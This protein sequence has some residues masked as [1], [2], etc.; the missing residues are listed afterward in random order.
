MVKDQVEARGRR[1]IRFNPDLDKDPPH[2]DSKSEMLSLQLNVRKRLQTAHRQAAL[3]NVAHRLVASSFYLELQ[4]KATAEKSEQVCAATIVCRF[5]DGSPELKA[6]GHIIQDRRVDDFDP[7]F[8]IK[9]NQD[10]KETS[11]KVTITI[12]V[13]RGMIDNG[14]F[15]LSNIYI[16]LRDET[17]ATSISLFLQKHDGLEPDGFPI[18][19]FPRVVLGDGPS[20]NPRP[21][22]SMRGSNDHSRR[23]K[24]SDG[25]TVS[26]N[27]GSHGG[28]SE[29]SSMHELKTKYSRA[30]NLSNKLSLAD[31]IGQH[32][33]SGTSI[34]SR[35]NR[36]WTYIGNNHM[37]QNPELY[38]ADELSKYAANAAAA[39][40]AE[41]NSPKAGRPPRTSSMTALPPMPTKSIS[42]P[43]LRPETPLS[44]GFT[45][46]D[47]DTQLPCLT[48]INNNHRTIASRAN[49]SFLDLSAPSEPD[50]TN[51]TSNASS[52]STS[53]GTF[54]RSNGSQSTRADSI[55]THRTTV[56]SMYETEEDD[57]DW[58]SGD[59]VS[60]GEAQPTSLVQVRI[61]NTVDSI[62]S[63][64][65]DHDVVY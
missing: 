60:L 16:P 48:D 2:G 51:H 38:T 49:T 11:F 32:Q 31:L 62:M 6:L 21:R 1:F 9:P 59:D 64:Y 54:T 44:P 28:D 36:F 25:D 40:A 18:S 8:L 56:P 30:G 43:Q 4:S 35:T 12:D 61:R 26:L 19:G 65:L 58:Y 15:D 13:A 24:S 27:G 45:E 5:D 34:K 41:E 20:T 3:R 46:L 47:M 22:R 57:G 55:S 42:L 63:L 52:T 7:Y 23:M 53:A 29:T 10:Q 37:A 39:A 33:N 50:I 17:K 14:V